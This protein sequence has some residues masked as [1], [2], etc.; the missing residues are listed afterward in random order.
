MPVLPWA[1]EASRDGSGAF[2][3]SKPGTMSQTGAGE[4]AHGDSHSNISLGVADQTMLPAAALGA[5]S[6]GA[7]TKP[8]RT[9]KVNVVATHGGH[10]AKDDAQYSFA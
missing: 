9:G 10:V 7:L 6:G 3:T 4:L 1:L 8:A 5:P 2:L